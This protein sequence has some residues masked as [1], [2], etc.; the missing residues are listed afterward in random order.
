MTY[1]KKL[2]NA[3]YDHIHDEEKNFWEIDIDFIKSLGSYYLA[4]RAELMMKSIG[5]P[6]PEGDM[7]IDKYLRI[8]GEFED[9]D[10]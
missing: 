7:D 5:K 3:V 6:L 1:W 4:I 8:L 2:L 10:E 9:E